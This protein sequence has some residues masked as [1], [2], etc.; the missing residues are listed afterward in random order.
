MSKGLI[1]AFKMWLKKYLQHKMTQ[2]FTNL[3]QHLNL[4][5]AII[6]LEEFQ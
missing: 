6:Q 4:S 1:L 3:L 2:F 5:T